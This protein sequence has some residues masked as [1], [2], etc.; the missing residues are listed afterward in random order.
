MSIENE[1]DRVISILRNIKQEKFD[2]E[3][4]TEIILTNFNTNQQSVTSIKMNSDKRSTRKPRSNT[5][6]VK[7]NKPAPAS[8]SKSPRPKS[9]SQSRSRKSLPSAVKPSS[10]QR[11]ASPARTRSKKAPSSN[12]GAKL[13]TKVNILICIQ[14]IISYNL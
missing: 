7:L 3:L 8:R 4:D 14:H 2:F 11:Q 6:E 5:V 13:Y 9:R 1:S 10:P 12:L